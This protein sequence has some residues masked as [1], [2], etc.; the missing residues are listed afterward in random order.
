MTLILLIS[1]QELYPD[2]TKVWGKLIVQPYQSWEPKIAASF[3]EA[4]KYPSESELPTSATNKYI[5][6]VSCTFFNK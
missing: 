6:A 5:S 3:S 2:S 4:T 1:Q